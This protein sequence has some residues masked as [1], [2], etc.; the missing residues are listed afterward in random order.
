MAHGIITARFIEIQTL[1]RPVWLVV[2]K[3][4]NRRP[5]SDD[6]WQSY[7]TETV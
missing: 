7:S 6:F 1:F 2:A 4:G 5:E 3:A